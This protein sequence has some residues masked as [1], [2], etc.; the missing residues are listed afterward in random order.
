MK[1]I[2]IVAA[3]FVAATASPAL[4]QDADNWTGFY[5]G[6]HFGYG[7]QPNDDDET[8]LFDTNLDG[9]F[10]ET[11]NTTAPA[12]AFSPGFCGGSAN[13]NAPAAG[14]RDDRDGIEFGI[15]AGYDYQAPGSMFVVGM[16]VDY[17][18]SRLRDS[19]TGFSTTPASYTMTRRLRD[20]ATFRG[21]LGLSTGRA[22]IYATGGLAYGSI[23]NSFT[24]TNTANAFTDNGDERG[25]G[26]VIGGGVEYRLAR[27]FSIGAE[28]LYRSIDAGDYVVRAGP[29][30]A[31][32]TNPFRI[33]NPNGTDFLRSDDRMSSH[34]LRLTANYRF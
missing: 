14:C 11:V 7:F 6:G 3:A 20:V 26:G 31:G 2:Q 13:G 22:L 5:V 8:I 32:L 4:A 16:A 21:R 1:P 24:T 9:R 15:Q 27:N 34:G 30:T 19:V 25:W 18:R 29:G 28:Y 17:S 23:R 10:G 12:N 33:V